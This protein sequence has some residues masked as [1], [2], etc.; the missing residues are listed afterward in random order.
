MSRLSRQKIQAIHEANLKVLGEQDENTKGTIQIQKFLNKKGITDDNGKSLDEDGLA[1]KSTEE[2]ISTYQTSL[3]VY[4]VDGVWGRD[5]MDK[6]P[7]ADRKLYDSLS[8]WW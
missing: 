2:A 1:G 8:S 4:P 5:T 7:P 6:M 3:R